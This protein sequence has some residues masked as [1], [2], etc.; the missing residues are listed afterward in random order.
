MVKVASKDQQNQWLLLCNYLV[1]I[2]WS[3][4]ISLSLNPCFFFFFFMVLTLQINLNLLISLFYKEKWVCRQNYDSVTYVLRIGKWKE[5]WW[6]FHGLFE[7]IRFWPLS[8]LLTMELW[9]NQ[10][11]KSLP[12]SCIQLLS[13]FSIRVVGGRERTKC[14]YHCLTAFKR[15]PV[16]QKG[17]TPREKL[18]P[19]DHK[20]YSFSCINLANVQF[21]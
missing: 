10:L 8:H 17:K 12:L 16:E 2:V 6:S 7:T 19:N 3:A 13:V 21:T 14:K 11:I 18:A 1:F 4:K 5:I 20:V 9:T 15:F